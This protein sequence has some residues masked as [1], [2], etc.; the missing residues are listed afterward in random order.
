MNL[1]DRRE[2]SILARLH[3]LDDLQELDAA[4]CVTK[5]MRGD[6]KMAYPELQKYSG[7]YYRLN[8]E[9]ERISDAFAMRY[10]SSV[11]APYGVTVRKFSK[12]CY[13]TL[14]C[15]CEIDSA[16]GEPPEGTEFFGREEFYALCQKLRNG[17]IDIDRLLNG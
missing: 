2:R 17:E 11:L 4:Y 5:K 16:S 10:A 1:D 14:F 6:K 3:V 13:R 9:L 15:F 12:Y 8:Y 7:P